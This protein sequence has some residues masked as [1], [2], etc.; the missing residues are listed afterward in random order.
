MRDYR[1]ID[2]LTQGY[3]ILVALLIA[4]FHGGFLPM[5]VLYVSAHVAGVVAIHALIRAT[6]RPRGWFLE[7]LR[8][9]YPMIL[10][11]LLYCETHELDRL[12]CRVALDGFFIDL[13][14]LI[15]GAQLSRTLMEALPYLWVSEVLYLF[16]FSYYVMVFGVGLALYFKKRRHYFHYLTVVS[17]VFYICYLTYIFLPVMGPHAT[18]TG[19]VFAGKTASVGPRVVP[20]SI[21]HGPFFNVMRLVYKFV[22]P[23]GGAAFPSSHVA[24]AIVTLWFTWIHLRKIRWLHMVAVV[25]L[26]LSTVYCGYHYVVDVLAGVVTAAILLPVGNVIYKRWQHLGPER[27]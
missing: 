25:M 19:V 8:C 7:M 10:Y 27:Q 21:Q 26:C 16:Y 23:E 22:E 14:Q 15:F 24:V 11:T 17:F 3:V 9:F 1:I 18:E 6:S 12:F 20:A 5:W 2:Y 13:D 4:L